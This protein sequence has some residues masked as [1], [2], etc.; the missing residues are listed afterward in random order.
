VGGVA[1]QNDHAAG[2]IGL[3]LLGVELITQSDVKD[4]ALEFSQQLPLAVSLL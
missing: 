4:A 1:R 3:Q 2:R